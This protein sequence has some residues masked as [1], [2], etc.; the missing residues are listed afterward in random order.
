MREIADVAV[1]F[2]TAVFTAALVV[3][4]GVWLLVLLGTAGR[5]SSYDA[6]SL[7]MAASASAVVVISWFLS[8]AGS[9]ALR[10]LA[11]PDPW[12]VPAASALLVGSSALALLV[13][14]WATRAWRD[15]LARTRKP[16]SADRRRK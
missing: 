11:L 4:A 5:D 15:R 1:G 16:G 6:L 8:A 12:H 7:P 13:T 2:P 3:L 10:R 9:L 14:R